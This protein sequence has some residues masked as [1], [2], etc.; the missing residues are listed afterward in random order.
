M[1]STSRVV[2]VAPN[3]VDKLLREVGVDCARFHDQTVK[4]LTP[5]SVECDEIWSYCYAKDMNL[6]VKGNPEFAGTLWT[7]VALDPETKLVIS[8]YVSSGR[9]EPEAYTFMSDLRSRIADG[10]MIAT[11]KLHSY[12][13]SIEAAFGNQ[14]THLQMTK[15]SSDDVCTSHIERHNGTTRTFVKRFARRTNAFSKKVRNHQLA[16]AL[17]FVWYNFCRPH[18]SLGPVTTPAMAAGLTEWPME[19]GNLLNL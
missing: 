19:I 17:Y 2:G 14:A 16:L 5:P 4:G 15:R 9:S 8:W 13:E 12:S 3:T 1:R 18:K 11:D 6:P 7:W 10:A